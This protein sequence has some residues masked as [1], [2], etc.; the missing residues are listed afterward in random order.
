MVPLVDGFSLYLLIYFKG[1]L[2]ENFITPISLY[3]ITQFIYCNI[4]FPTIFSP[5][6]SLT[7][8]EISQ[9]AANTPLFCSLLA[10]SIFLSILP[11]NPPQSHVFFTIFFFPAITPSSSLSIPP[12]F[13]LT[14]LGFSL[15][16]YKPKKH[17]N[18]SI[19]DPRI[20]DS[21]SYFFLSLS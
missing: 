5:S 20:S 12:N 21:Q 19:P 16:P 2:N 17:S 10:C 3:S 7:H 1:H 13:Q 9:S 14:R 8:T 6:L 18:N 15:L 11:F 4:L